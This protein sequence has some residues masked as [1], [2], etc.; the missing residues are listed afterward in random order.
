MKENLKKYLQSL[1]VGAKDTAGNRSLFDELYDNL[2]ARYDDLV[3]GGAAPEDAFADAIGKLGDIKP[4]IEFEE[5][6]K[7][8]ADGAENT[9]NTQKSVPPVS[10]PARHTEKKKRLAPGEL[11]R[12]KRIRAL[13][14]A[15]AVMLYILWLVPVTLFDPYAISLFL[16]IAAGTALLLLTRSMTPD[17][18]DDSELSYD[19]LLCEHDRKLS[20]ILLALGVA[21]C[22]LCIIP[23]SVIP[24]DGG[25]ALMFATVA[26]GVGM[27]IFSAGIAPSLD[28]AAKKPDYQPLSAT[29]NGNYPEDGAKNRKNKWLLPCVII[30]VLA[31][32]VTGVVNLYFGNFHFGFFVSGT[33]PDAYVNAGGSE[34]SEVVDSI[35][36]DWIA[37][38][39]TVVTDDGTTVRFSETAQNGKELTD[40]DQLRWYLEDGHLHIRF[41]G[42]GNFRFGFQKD[43]EKNLMLYL[44]AGLSLKNVKVDCVSA[45]ARFTGITA[46]SVADFDTV[47]GD[48]WLADCQFATLNANS[49]SGAFDIVN[50]DYR[51]INID[52]VSGELRLQNAIADCLD[53]DSTS[54]DCKLAGGRILDID[55][56]TASGRLTIDAEKDLRSIDFD[57]IS[58]DLQLFLAAD[59][60]GFTADFDSVSGKFST[61]LPTTEKE[62]HR[63]FGDGALRIKMDGTSGS[64]TIQVNDRNTAP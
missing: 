35:S 27:I 33:A 44:P 1:F 54:G 49:V 31:L 57:T 14:L 30:A 58:G 32:L 9:A 25:P 64:L 53:F 21:L 5:N 41:D 51:F 55:A 45:A 39:V 8:P 2:A 59:A 52:T 34:I 12:V 42:Y 16:C 17:Y 38:R 37:G 61:P 23:P 13:G 28:K 6:T 19:P 46:A 63:L 48:I 7:R 10:E 62:G 26:L 3:A 50:G 43:P 29:E 60:T 36:L 18:I 11:R 56:D 20:N 4:L 47:S 15:G 40:K 22:I 24:S